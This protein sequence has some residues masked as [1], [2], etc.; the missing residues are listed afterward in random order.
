MKNNVLFL[1]MAERCFSFR[2]FVTFLVCG[3][4]LC[5]VCVCVCFRH[6]EVLMVSCFVCCV[7]GKVAN[8][9][10][11]LFS[12]FLGFLGGVFILVDLGL[13]GLGFS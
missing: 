7:F 6:F 2:C 8:V 10:K 3:G 12:Q 9:S 11:S 1:N 13:E 5:G 4:W